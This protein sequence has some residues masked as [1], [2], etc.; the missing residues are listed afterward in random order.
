MKIAILISDTYNFL[1]SH[2]RESIQ[3]I[4]GIEFQ[5]IL[6]AYTALLDDYISNLNS[7]YYQMFF[8]RHDEEFFIQDIVRNANHGWLVANYVNSKTYEICSSILFAI[9][10]GRTYDRP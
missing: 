8:K 6:D 10:L 5:N 9:P 2:L 4:D 3:Y 1:D 7:K